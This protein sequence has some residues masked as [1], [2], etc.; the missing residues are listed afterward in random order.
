M[1]CH[2]HIIGACSLDR[3]TIRPNGERLDRVTATLSTLPDEDL[4][5]PRQPVGSTSLQG[6]ARLELVGS[7]VR[8]RVASIQEAQLQTRAPDV[9]RFSRD[10]KLL[11]A[12]SGVFAVSFY[13]VHIMLR[14]LYVLRLGHGPE[15]IG[16]F[17]A[18]GALT[19]MGMSLPGGALGGRF[20]A[21]R[22]MLA[23]G[24]IAVIAM[25]L[26][27]LTEYMPIWAQYHWPIV[28]G[29]VLT[30]G[31]SLVNVN[32]VPAL[33][34]TT[35]PENRKSAFAINSALRG[36]GTFL[37]TVTGGLLPALFASLISR[38]L[39]DPAPYRLALW[40]GAALGL[41][42]LLPLVLVGEVRSTATKER[43]QACG[44][45]P[46]L[47]ILL[48]VA[49]VYLSH[50]GW[51]T[52]QAFFNAYMDTVLQ[53]P[54]SSIGLITGAGQLAAVLA[55]LLAQRLTARRGEGWTMMATSVGIA[56]SLVPLAAMSHWAAAAV[57]RIGILAFS[58]AWMP[59]LQVYQMETVAPE[60]RSLA[61][62][63]MSMAMG[64]CYG[65][66]SL[67]GGYIIAASGYRSIF[68][69]GIGLSA[70]GALVM[71]GILRRHRSAVRELPA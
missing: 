15:Y 32:L 57:G 1:H 35:T 29:M 60:W 31:W 24:V 9:P 53:M 36:L 52:S 54:A 26:F 39:D 30:M 49:H 8:E 2:E 55:P 70:A 38:S 51:A 37:G 34:A 62:G 4:F 3:D 22:V 13:G 45:F 14:I 66:V 47:P 56:I 17:G 33:M 41:V 28:S 43:S 10:A 11:L 7:T 46:L 19:Y 59:A 64:F 67:A 50:G 23:G 44:P 5:F 68:T 42:A 12:V 65:S 48:L 71:Q 58:A 6:I 21:R 25:G 27:P 40:V 20:G 69:L 61:Y 16:L 63:A 18:A